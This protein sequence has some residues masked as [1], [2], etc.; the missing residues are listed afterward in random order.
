VAERGAVMVEDP[1]PLLPN[2]SFAELQKQCPIPILVDGACRSFAMTKLFV[3]HR[4][5][6]FNLKLQKARGYT[7]NWQIAR[8]ATERGCDVNI[9]MFGETSLGSLAALQMSAALPNRERCVPAEVSLFLMLPDEYVR[10][11]LQVQGGRVRLPDAPG[12]ARLVDWDK[13][14]RLSP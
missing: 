14:A 5:K 4:A 13:V 3:E 12:M 11:P 1:C 7:E 6:A 8:F 2:S 10:E 9:G